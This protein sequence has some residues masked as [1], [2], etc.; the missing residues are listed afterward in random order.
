M[1]VTCEK[2]E[3][4]F[5]VPDD[6][7]GAKGRKVRCSSCSH[8]WHVS[9]P[10]SELPKPEVPQ[11]QEAASQRIKAETKTV[12]TTAKVVEDKKP[13]VSTSL[14][15]IAASILILLNFGAFVLFNKEIIG[16][17]A[18]Y[19]MVGQYDTKAVE[20]ENHEIIATPQPNGTNLQISWVVKNTS[21]KQA[22]MPVVR[23][24][25]LDDKLELVGEKINA[26]E[27]V[28]MAAGQELKFKDNL[29]HKT[30]V[31]R[32]FTVEIGNETELATR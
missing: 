5:N 19:D 26:R 30:K 8:V 12:K 6:K 28:K 2:C 16:Q 1:I 13:F 32:Y 4:K 25:L 7:I 24:R 31:A 23:F 20:I 17:T 11:P 18:F 21:S 14:L 9:L 27:N 29:I 10:T 3:T 22:K 15:K